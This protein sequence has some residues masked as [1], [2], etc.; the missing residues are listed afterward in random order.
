MIWKNENPKKKKAK[1][2]MLVGGVNYSFERVSDLK[3]VVWTLKCFTKFVSNDKSL[4]TKIMN[5]SE[6]NM[7]KIQQ[8]VCFEV[9]NVAQKRFKVVWNFY[10]ILNSSISTMCENFN[11]FE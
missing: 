11:K 1:R 10:G 2:E 3:S 9:P 8:V 7:S 4:L 5:L 6:L